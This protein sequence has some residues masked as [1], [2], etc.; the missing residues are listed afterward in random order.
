MRILTRRL[1]LA[2]LM[3]VLLTL[4]A[5]GAAFAHVTVKPESAP[6]GSYS[7]LSFRVPNE[8]DD[9]GTTGV[10]VTFPTDTPI[11]SVRVKPVAGWEYKIEMAQL[12]EPIDTGHG[13]VSEVVGKITWSGGTINPGEYQDFPVSAGPLPEDADQLVFKA[14]QTYASGEVVRWIQE[15]AEGAEE[16]EHPA[17]VLALTAAEGDGHDAAADEGDQDAAAVSGEAAGP[18]QDEL[19]AASQRGTIGIVLGSL[20]LLLGLVALYLST[21]RRGPGSMGEAG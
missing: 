8:R 19:D 2:S 5:A 3:A 14:V 15:A 20:G 11:S 6:K 13:Q 7:E 16:P 1:A 4:A 10:E 18:T 9:S 17:P 12:P 21:R